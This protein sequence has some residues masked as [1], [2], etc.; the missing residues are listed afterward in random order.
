MHGSRIVLSA[1]GKSGPYGSKK[2]RRFFFLLVLKLTVLFTESSNG[3]FQRK[4][5][6]KIGEGGSNNFQ[7]VGFNFFKGEGVQLLF[8][9]ETRITCDFPGGPET[10]YP[11]QDPNMLVILCP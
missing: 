8:P 4:L 7:G 9:I 5:L 1:D 2:A 11:P 6:S 3:L 10:L